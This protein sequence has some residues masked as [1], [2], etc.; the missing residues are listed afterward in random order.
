MRETSRVG[1]FIDGGYFAVVSDYFRYEHERRAR[2]HI[3]GIMEHIKFLMIDKHYTE[4]PDIVIKRYFRGRFSASETADR[5]KLMAERAWDEVLLL[6]GFEARYHPNGL[7]GEKAIDVMLAL[8]A[9]K[10]A[11][12]GQIDIAVFVTGDEDF[13]PLF[14]ELRRMGVLVV[15]LGCEQP[16]TADNTHFSVSSVLKAEASYYQDLWP[17]LSSD[18][19]MFDYLFVGGFE[20]E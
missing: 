15:L 14:I 6:S 16:V 2:V 20:R 1:L 10:A 8:D 12:R 5:G 9:Y 19:E 13:T 18:G 17:L 7:R 3:G 11:A 4:Y